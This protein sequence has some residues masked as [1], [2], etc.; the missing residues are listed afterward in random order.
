[1]AKKTSKKAPP[2]VEPKFSSNEACEPVYGAINRAI[3]G[4]T[5]RQS[6]E[7][8]GEIADHCEVMAEELVQE[9]REDELKWGLGL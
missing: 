6:M 5:K 7:V 8:L 4:L 2:K 1:M 9:I 3:R